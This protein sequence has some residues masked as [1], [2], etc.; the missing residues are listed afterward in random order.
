MIST[1]LFVPCKLTW[2]FLLKVEALPVLM[3][4]D[5]KA[6]C[7]AESL[8]KASGARSDLS[9]PSPE[10]LLRIANKN[11]DKRH[12]LNLTKNVLH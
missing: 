11:N 7:G 8:S 1:L 9:T 6:I 10:Q 2:T 4:I 12:M 5:P 3:D